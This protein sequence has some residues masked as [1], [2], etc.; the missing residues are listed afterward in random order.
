MASQLQG[1]RA[2]SLIEVLVAVSI[3][4]TL[5]VI[6]H[7][8]FGGVKQAVSD[9]DCRQRLLTIH[10]AI[11]Q[12]RDDNRRQDPVLLADLVPKYLQADDLICPVVRSRAPDAI[13]KVR[14]SL[15][16]HP[17]RKGWPTYFYFSRRKL[18]RLY[19]KKA[20]A[21]SYSHVLNLRGGRTPSVACLDHR[22]PHSLWYA[23]MATPEMMRNWYVPAGAVFVLRRSGSVDTS[24]Y[25]GLILDGL[26]PS[27]EALAMNL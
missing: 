1:R 6:I 19:E 27:T 16:N 7:S 13:E 5:L 20:I 25:G 8:S 9:V 18:D 12:F 2:A 21:V 4:L 26:N 11:Q 14:A 10:A 15:V 22:E 24:H 3:I 17:T 23:G